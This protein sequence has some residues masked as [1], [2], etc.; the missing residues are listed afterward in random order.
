[1]WEPLPGLSVGVE[2]W[3]IRK[4]NVILAIDPND[5]LA[6]EDGFGAAYVTRGPVDP[7][8]PTLPGPIQSINVT[9]Q[10]LGSV[11]TS[12]FDF[13]VKART[14]ATAFGAFQFSLDGT[15]IQDFTETLPDTRRMRRPDAMVSTGRFR[16]GGTTRSSIGSLGR[17][18]QHLDRRTNRDWANCVRTERRGG[19]EATASGTCRAST[20][21]GAMRQWRWA[22]AICSTEIRPRLR[23]CSAAYDPF[24]ADTRGRTFYARVSYAFK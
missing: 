19:S 12:G 15:Y 6:H 17:G 3:K 9:N 21:A 14:G 7:A 5:V 16:A 8:Y 23:Q 1:V 18:V 4:N 24:Y 11:V 20:P 13:T 2:W 10:N 22:F